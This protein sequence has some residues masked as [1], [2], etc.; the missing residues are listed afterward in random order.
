MALAFQTKKRMRG[1]K[2][3]SNSFTFKKQQHKMAY[4]QPTITKNITLPLLNQWIFFESEKSL[5]YS[6]IKKLEVLLT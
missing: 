4:L 5:G 6:T 3:K 1:L 2:C